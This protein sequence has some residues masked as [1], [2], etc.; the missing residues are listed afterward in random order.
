[1]W[2]EDIER[3]VEMNELMQVKLFIRRL[4]VD[5]NVFETEIIFRQICNVMEM[6]K[7]E[8]EIPSNRHKTIFESQEVNKYWIVS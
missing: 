2:K 7:K 4:K 6:I 1:M 5:V 8:K 3:H